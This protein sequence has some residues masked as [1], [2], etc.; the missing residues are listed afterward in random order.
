[1]LIEHNSALEEIVI[2]GYSAGAQYVQKYLAGTF[3]DETHASPASVDLRYVVMAP[4]SY[5]WLVS[6]RPE[7]TSGC[8]NYNEYK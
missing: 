3:V 1:M 8:S 2:V 7:A 6:G 4:R 5:M